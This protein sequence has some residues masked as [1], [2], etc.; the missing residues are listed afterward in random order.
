MSKDTVL[1]LHIDVFECGEDVE[2]DVKMPICLNMAAMEED[3]S[4]LGL[5]SEEVEEQ[6]HT[7]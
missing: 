4:W 5:V 6:N 7:S 2:S 3:P 1:T